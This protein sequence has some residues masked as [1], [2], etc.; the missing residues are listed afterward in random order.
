MQYLKD[1]IRDKILNASL[2]EFLNKGFRDAS[3][4]GIS[5]RSKLAIGSI[6]RY[7][8][9]K[10]AIFDYLISPVYNRMKMQSDQ[11]F[12]KIASTNVTYKNFR[13]MELI[14]DICN[15]QLENYYEHSAEILILFDKCQGT[16]YENYYKE[17]VEVIYRILKEVYVEE[18]GKEEVRLPDEA[19]LGVIAESF[20][21]G[22]YSILKTASNP[23]QLSTLTKMFLVATFHDL[24]YS[25]TN[26]DKIDFFLSK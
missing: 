10:E 4:R 11:L 19:I 16:K 12:Q 23:L 24:A 6:Y 2:E 14:K 7:F 21:A 17:S 25:L 26:A 13:S 9:S 22:F 5:K 15:K 8:E 20:T 1:D 3:I 18:L